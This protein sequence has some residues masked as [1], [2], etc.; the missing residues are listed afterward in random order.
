MLVPPPFD[1]FMVSSS[2][3]SARQTTGAARLGHLP[4]C[5]PSVRPAPYLCVY[6]HTPSRCSVVIHAGTAVPRYVSTSTKA[7]LVL[8]HVSSLDMPSALWARYLLLLVC[9][10]SGHPAALGWLAVRS[11]RSN[12][13]TSMSS[14]PCYIVP[15]CPPAAPPVLRRPTSGRVH[16]DS[17]TDPPPGGSLCCHPLAA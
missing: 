8:F 1:S 12:E 6:S 2:T 3:Y 5:Y 9:P 14:S 16:S 7:P 13:L 15:V 11:T 17:P 10:L 4:R